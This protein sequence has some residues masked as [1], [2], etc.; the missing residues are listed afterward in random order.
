MP[1]ESSKSP[2]MLDGV[3]PAKNKEGNP[4][5][6][7]AHEV[8]TVRK[9]VST[10]GS[11]ENNEC[12]V[13][14]DMIFL[15]YSGRGGRNYHTIINWDGK[16]YYILFFQTH[17]NELVSV[18]RKISSSVEFELIMHEKWENRLVPWNVDFASRVEGVAEFRVNPSSPDKIVMGDFMSKPLAMKLPKTFDETR[19]FI[20]SNFSTF[21]ITFFMHEKWEQD[22]GPHI[23]N[24]FSKINGYLRKKQMTSRDFVRLVK[25]EK[26]NRRSQLEDF[27]SQM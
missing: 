4:E 23:V 24:A 7:E 27:L 10:N 22:S 18:L 19:L 14:D 12:E 8:C 1:N 21:D 3:S 2:A 16:E 26:I 9:M 17:W 11:K 20:G 13:R 5:S 25:S 6:P 15:T